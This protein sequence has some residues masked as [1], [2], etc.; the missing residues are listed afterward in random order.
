MCDFRQLLCLARALLKDPVVLLMD[1]AT[2]SIDYSTDTKIQATIHEL[3]STTITIA[4]RLNSIIFYDKV[5]VLDQGEV[6]EF[7][8]PH[9]LLQKKDSIFREMCESSG[10]LGAL[11]E[12][13]KRAFMGTG[14]LIET[15]EDDSSDT[16]PHVVVM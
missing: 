3:K 9:S 13:A 1:E 5:L 8:H 4:H 12:M 14:T 11:E 7:D 10:E 15:T 2:A 16:D 6:K